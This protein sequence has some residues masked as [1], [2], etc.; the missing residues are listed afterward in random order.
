[1]GTH[2][3]PLTSSHRWIHILFHV[4][5]LRNFFIS[6][7]SLLCYLSSRTLVLNKTIIPKVIYYR[8]S[9][10]PHFFHLYLASTSAPVNPV[11]IPFPRKQPLPA[12]LSSFRLSVILVPLHST[13]NHRV[14]LCTC[15]SSS[16]SAYSI[17]KCAA[18][19]REKSSV[20]MEK[21]TRSDEK[22]MMMMMVMATRMKETGTSNS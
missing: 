6:Y 19:L 21:K 8:V 16:S 18:S 7:P 17:C 11:N 13:K 2:V 9:F 15:A 5:V 3:A 1:M 12:I 22:D 10:W 4:P 14:C 20:P